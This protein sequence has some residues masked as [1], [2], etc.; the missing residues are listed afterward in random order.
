MSDRKQTTENTITIPHRVIFLGI[1]LILLIFAYVIFR[2]DQ[3]DLDNKQET[4]SGD[5]ENITSNK[6]TNEKPIEPLIKNV[7]LKCPDGTKYGEC[8]GLYLCENGQLIKKVPEC[9]CEEGYIDMGDYCQI[10]NRIKDRDDGF[11]HFDTGNITYTFDLENPCNSD[12]KKRILWAL[13]LLERETNNLITYTESE[14]GE[15]MI[16]CYDSYDTTGDYQPGRVAGRGGPTALYEGG[17]IVSSKIMFYKICPDCMGNCGSY[18]TTELH[19]ILHSLGLDDD[20]SHKYGMMNNVARNECNPI[21][22]NIKK[23]LIDVYSNKNSK[24]VCDYVLH[25]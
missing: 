17:L 24:W 8:I 20:T 6:I 5:S 10:D 16:S 4:V 9:G 1:I 11:P 18:P 3:S 25:F 19:E 2:N 12:K 7:E 13:N 23:C 21:E 22:E 14:D 15:V